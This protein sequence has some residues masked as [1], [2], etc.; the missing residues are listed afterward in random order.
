[1]SR[2]ASVVYPVALAAD[3]ASTYQRAAKVRN[4]TVDALLAEIVERVAAD[5]LFQAVL[6]D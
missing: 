6:D 2:R 4:M 5:N 1:M 3:T